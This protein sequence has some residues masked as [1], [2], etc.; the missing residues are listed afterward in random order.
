MALKEASAYMT[1]EERKIRMNVALG[2]MN[3]VYTDMCHSTT[4]EVSRE[5]VREFCYF[6]IETRKFAQKMFD[7]RNKGV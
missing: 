2:I 6:L 4:D 3:D 7:K 1:N 5:D